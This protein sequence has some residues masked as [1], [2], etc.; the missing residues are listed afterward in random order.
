MLFTAFP[1]RTASDQETLLVLNSADHKIDNDGTLVFI[2]GTPRVSEPI[3]DTDFNISVRAMRLQ[4][5]VEMYQWQTDTAEGEGNTNRTQRV[6]SNKPLPSPESA[7][8]EVR[9]P[10][11]MPRGQRQQDA[12]LITL[13]AFTLSPRLIALL[14]DY[15]PVRIDDPARLGRLRRLGDDYFRG[16]NPREPVVGDLKV[17]YKAVF[18]EPLSLTARLRGRM[19]EPDPAGTIRAG[20]HPPDT[21]YDGPIQSLG[22]RRQLNLSVAFGSLIFGGGLIGWGWTRRRVPTDP[23]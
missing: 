21:L 14:D 10:K 8:P 6:W 13:G 5:Q 22:P 1:A 16:K 15:Q 7:P 19:L 9:N 23:V 18:P 20:L 12:G 11:R 4:R 2:S 3:Y 17:T